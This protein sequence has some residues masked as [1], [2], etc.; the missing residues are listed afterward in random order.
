MNK[1]ANELLKIKAVF[2]N[3][4]NPF[5]WAS[6]IKSP[7]YTDNR[8]IISYPKTRE[9]IESAL[10]QLIKQKFPNVTAVVGTA[11]AGIPHAA[12]VSAK[13]NLPMAYVRAKVKDHGRAKTIEGEIANKKVVVIEDLLSTG[14]SCIEV[15][16]ILKQ[17]KV[18]VLGA[19][20]IFNYELKECI[21]NFKQNKIKYFSLCTLE[22]MLS[23][24]VDKKY[25]TIKQAQQIIKFRNDPKS[26]SW[27]IN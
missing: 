3:V 10:A 12:Y 16:K 24:A 4:N 23:C 5:T 1:V 17:N 20:S 14:N 6:G 19:I 27:R 2:F 22:Q 21:Q 25:V 9:I 7:I 13:L 26:E 15:I 11:T 8:I 18:Q